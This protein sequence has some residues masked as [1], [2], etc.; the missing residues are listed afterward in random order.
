[1]DRNRWAKR[2]LNP[3]SWF[4]FVGLA[5]ANY[6]LDCCAIG[7]AHGVLRSR[8][9]GPPQHNIRPQLI[10]DQF[11]WDKAIFLQHYSHQLQKL[12]AKLGGDGLRRAAY[13]AG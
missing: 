9:Q 10:R 13:R 7:C 5:D 12:Y 3:A 8:D 6:P 11:V 2:H 4:R 1:M